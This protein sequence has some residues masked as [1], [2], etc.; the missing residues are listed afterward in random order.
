MCPAS[1][2]ATQILRHKF[3]VL[4][5]T[6]VANICGGGYKNMTNSSNTIKYSIN[7]AD[8]IVE[9][10][11]EWDIFAVENDSPPE[12]FSG[13]ILHRSFW[14]FVSG[15]ALRHVYRRI[16]EQVRA[17]KTMD[18]SF[19]CDSPDLRRF[20]SLQMSPIADGGIE[21]VTETICTEARKYQNV[22]DINAPR[23]GQVIV[24]CSWCNKLKSGVNTWQEP[25]DAICTL[26]LFETDTIPTLSHGMC[27]GCYEMVL[28][29]VKTSWI[30][31]HILRQV[32]F[33]A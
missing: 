10:G 29:T 3:A 13:S 11:G 26:S 2:L 6:K 30:D 28:G 17:G 19:R 14:D 20:L 7:A 25:E 31:T 32:S 27:N 4:A 16:M 15:D 9:V 24:A 22:F 5:G 23:T 33:A 21:F 18:F 12:L 1:Y 8:E